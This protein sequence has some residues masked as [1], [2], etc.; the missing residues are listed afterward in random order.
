MQTPISQRG[1]LTCPR[2]NGFD[3]QGNDREG[4]KQDSFWEGRRPAL[5][6]RGKGTRTVETQE[7]GV[8]WG[9]GSRP[10]RIMDTVR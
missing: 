10:G 6:V 1:K 4:S 2:D 9:E 7:L 5:P 3:S 8:W